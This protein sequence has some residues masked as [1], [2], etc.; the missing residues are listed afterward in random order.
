M[1]IVTLQLA[2]TAFF[3]FSLVQT[4]QPLIAAEN[5]QRQV[6]L[7]S[8]AN[9]TYL[10]PARGDLAPSAATLWGDR[11]SNVSTGF[12]LKPSDNFQSP[13]HIHNVSYRGV[14]IRGLLHND[15]PDATAMWMPAGSFWTQPRGEVHITA[16]KG[17]DTLAY[18]EIEGGPY[19]V[20]PSE[21]SFD[22]G[23]RPVNVDP[24]NIVWMDASDLNRIDQAPES[25]EVA[26]LWGSP[27]AGHLNGTFIKL[28][29]GYEGEISSH[30]STFRAVLIQGL[31]RYQLSATDLK[32][33]EPGSYFSSEGPALHPISSHADQETIL[34]VRTDGKYDI[35]ELN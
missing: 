5:E 35:T 11:N 4:A 31:P 33:L 6:V 13:P 20:L 15:D 16:A 2:L 32:T 12:L 21:E 3:C 14:V 18:I 9:W 30:G 17:T 34:Y 25:P 29:A 19:L 24:S 8:E 22:S 27:K 7:K 26:F 23:E 1:K 28:P 10:N